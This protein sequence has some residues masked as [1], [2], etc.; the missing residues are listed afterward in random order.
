V[1][2]CSVARDYGLT[3]DTGRAIDDY[4]LYST[5]FI[6]GSTVYLPVGRALYASEDNGA[7]WSLRYPQANYSDIVLV[8]KNLEGTLVTIGLGSYLYWGY[9]IAA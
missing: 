9:E 6:D 5:L 3:W 8:G 4:H 2:Y 7:T 1:A